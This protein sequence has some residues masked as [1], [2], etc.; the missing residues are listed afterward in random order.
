[1][2]Y[3]AIGRVQRY[4]HVVGKDISRPMGNAARML[5]ATM[6]QSDIRGLGSAFHRCVAGLPRS[7]VGDHRVDARVEAPR[8]PLI[9]NVRRVSDRVGVGF[10][11]ACL[12]AGVG[13][14]AW[15]DQ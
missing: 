4:V 8:I 1:M 13:M 15:A 3:L 2:R 14:D 6:D 7:R 12:L 9:V 11:C 5:V 10:A